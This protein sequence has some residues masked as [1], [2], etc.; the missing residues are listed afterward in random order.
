MGDM[1]KHLQ[2]EGKEDREES[3]NSLNR[4]SAQ[5]KEQR[6]RYVQTATEQHERHKRHPCPRPGPAPPKTTGPGLAEKCRSTG[7][8]LK[9]AVLTKS[10]RPI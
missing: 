1:S 3:E 6:R 5:N 10:T 7:M 8:S 4:G 2:D 9:H